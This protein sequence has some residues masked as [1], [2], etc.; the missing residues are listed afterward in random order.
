MLV[1]LSSIYGRELNL[2][3]VYSEAIIVIMHLTFA[4]AYQHLQNGLLVGAT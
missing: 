1:A 3:W 2:L 4:T